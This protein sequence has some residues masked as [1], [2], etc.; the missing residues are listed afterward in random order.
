VP[1]SPRTGAILGGRRPEQVDGW[2]GAGG[3]L[4]TAEARTAILSAIADTGA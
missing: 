1:A 3:L 4:L 2:I